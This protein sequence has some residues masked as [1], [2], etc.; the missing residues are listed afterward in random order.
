MNAQFF[1]AWSPR[2]LSLLR[3]VAGVLFFEHG[4][5]KLFGVPAGP[6]NGATPELFSLLGGAGVLE[7][8]G[9]AYATGGARPL[10]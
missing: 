7:L 10:R 8:V 6:A 1:D 2:I 4:T 9:G 3:I 5:Q